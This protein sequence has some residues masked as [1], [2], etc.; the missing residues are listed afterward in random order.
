MML[1]VHV[2]IVVFAIFIWT[3]LLFLLGRRQQQSICARVRG[4]RVMLIDR[5]LCSAEIFKALQK[6]DETATTLGFEP[7]PDY[8]QDTAVPGVL[9]T[10]IAGEQ[11]CYLVHLLSLKKAL[12]KGSD[13]GRNLGSAHPPTTP[14]S[15]TAGVTGKITTTTVYCT[16]FLDD[17]E[18]EHAECVLTSDKPLFPADNVSLEV[19]PP[20]TDTAGLIRRHR[21]RI[22][23]RTRLLNTQTSEPA[24]WWREIQAAN[25]RMARSVSRTLEHFYQ[26]PGRS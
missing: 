1:F 4:G 24:A 16:T 12:F 3:A 5:D 25:G 15:H 17:A 6:G 26:Q 8:A 11:D 19:L 9:H 13:A 14:G 2:V 20:G 22:G 21:E 23:A 18:D 7:L 10:C